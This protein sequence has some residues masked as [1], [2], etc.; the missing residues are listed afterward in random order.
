MSKREQQILGYTVD[1]T[2]QY[3]YGHLNLTVR[4]YKKESVREKILG[5][6]DNKAGYGNPETA[7]RLGVWYKWLLSKGYSSIYDTA[8]RSDGFSI[9]W[10]EHNPS[11][12]PDL[13]IEYGYCG[14]RVKI[15]GHYDETLRICKL[16]E[17]IGKKV[18]AIRSK[19]LEQEAEQTIEPGDWVIE[20]PGRVFEALN[21]MG[22]KRLTLI[23]SPS[24]YYVSAWV[25]DAS[26]L[27]W[28]RSDDLYKLFG[29]S[30]F[31]WMR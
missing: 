2:T 24:D 3:S 4:K 25:I 27:M 16:V 28:V 6:I 21:A 15:D 23:H 5:T 19:E 17:K 30:G 13:D 20:N 22:A 12:C 11:S 9:E 31:P 7:E 18:V 1:K 29:L 14:A 10:Q 8:W 26:P